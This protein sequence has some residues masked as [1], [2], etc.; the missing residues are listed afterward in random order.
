[1]LGKKCFGDLVK[2]LKI[3]LTM[4]LSQK[5]KKDISTVLPLCCFSAG[6]HWMKT[7]GYRRLIAP[8]MVAVRRSGGQRLTPAEDLGEQSGI[9][10]LY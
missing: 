6:V 5:K 1:M 9:N 7:V 8:L 2:F 10:Y 3:K 4:K